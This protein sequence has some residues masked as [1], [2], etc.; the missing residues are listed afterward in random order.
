MRVRS[1]VPGPCYAVC[2]C[3]GKRSF[4][5]AGCSNKVEIWQIPTGRSVSI[6][7]GHVGRVMS[8]MCHRSHP[9]HIDADNPGFIASGDDKGI[10]RTWLLEEPWTP[11]LEIKAH[12][13]PI[14]SITLKLPFDNSEDGRYR[15]L[16]TSED[17][18]FRIFDAITGECLGRVSNHNGP[19]QGLSILNLSGP[20]K[21]RSS[22]KS[23]TATSRWMEDIV[24]TCGLDKRINFW[25]LSDLSLL[26]CMERTKPIRGVSATIV[27]RPLMI[28]TCM[29]EGVEII[30][31]TIYTDLPSELKHFLTYHE[32]KKD[33][34]NDEKI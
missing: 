26:H 22:E 11:L 17:K 1:L 34:D 14:L 27:P 15:L 24:L 32:P 25:R 10:M 31:L 7:E 4:L 8:I 16:T 28:A 6:L 33:D 30:D 2:I 12:D 13:G 5:I 23:G 20:I 19:I 18:T 9:G 21:T 3:E 29:D